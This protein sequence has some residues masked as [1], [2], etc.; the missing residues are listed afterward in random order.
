ML[1]KRRIA[2]LV[3]G[4][5]VGAQVGVAAVSETSETALPP[6]AGQEYVEPAPAQAESIAPA[7]A[8][9]ESLP[10]AESP[11]QAEY[12]APAPALSESTAQVTVAMDEPRGIRGTMASIRARVLVRV[13]GGAF[14]V[15]NS[16][17]DVSMLPAQ[18]AYFDRLEADRIAAGIQWVARGDA[19]PR[20]NSAD[21]VSL[22]PA[23]IAH[24]DR[25][26]VRLAAAPRARMAL[27]GI[28]R[29][30]T[31]ESSNQELTDNTSLRESDTK[32]KD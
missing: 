12:V 29:P 22:L 23:Q 26:D 25:T 2:V 31:P 3:A 14:P 17:D 28:F 10:Q 20:S 15:S 1:S 7:P 27:S 21:D 18:V 30:S 5:F 4:L 9:A 19:F 13:G 32:P 8:Q 24:F 16:I 6:S 11:A